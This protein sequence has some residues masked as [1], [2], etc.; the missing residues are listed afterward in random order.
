MIKKDKLNG[1]IRSISDSEFIDFIGFPKTLED[2]A[3]KWSEILYD[4]CEEVV[5]PSLTLIQAKE[6][7]RLE[8]LK[9]NNN[10]KQFEIAV[11]K[12]ADTMKNGM[13]GFNVVLPVVPL[14]MSP[15]FLKGFGGANSE[16]IA[17]LMSDFLFSWFKTGIAVNIA[18]GVTIN[19][20]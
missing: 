5:P 11:T 6:L 14:D 4:F 9:I 7:S 19:W 15:I 13:I 12:F 18:S 10:P 1:G 17:K 16:E 2:A 8:F 3:I 20:N